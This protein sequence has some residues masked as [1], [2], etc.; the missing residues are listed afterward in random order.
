MAIDRDLTATQRTD[1]SLLFAYLAVLLVALLIIAGGAT[2]WFSTDNSS[3]NVLAS[4]P[5][6]LTSTAE[7]VKAN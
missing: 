5:Q 1:R 3:T 4:D 6:A 7:P 2:V